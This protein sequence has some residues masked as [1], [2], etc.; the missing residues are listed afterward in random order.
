MLASS[1][2]TFVGAVE[3]VAAAGGPVAGEELSAQGI[4]PQ[5]AEPTAQQQGI[6]ADKTCAC[7]NSNRAAGA[8]TA[9][10]ADSGSPRR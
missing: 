9:P 4:A 5:D 2:D 3:A 8:G 1:L 6:E 7:G 10:T